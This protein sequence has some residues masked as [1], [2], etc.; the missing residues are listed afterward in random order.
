MTCAFGCSEIDNY[1]IP[2][3][4]IYGTVIDDISGEPIQTEQ[5]NGYRMKL[6]KPDYEDAIP[7]Y[8]WGMEDGSFQNTKIASDRYEIVP[9]DG[10]FFPPEPKLVDVKGFTELSFAVTPF[11]KIIDV[12]V[13]SEGNSIIT[14]YALS[15][16]KIGEKIAVQATLC[17]ENPH[18]NKT[19]WD[20]RVYSDLSGIAD[21]TILATQSTDTIK[22]LKSGKT[23]YIR[24]G[25]ATANALS[26]FNY[27]KTFQI[28]IQ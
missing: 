1:S 10:A 4:G 18:V 19:V 5:P 11:L 23:Y 22:G 17:S 20:K 2:D 14:S 21:E 16:N 8:F 24:V 28:T 26:R 13:K 15:R 12:N 9:V 27:S 7:L 3:A 6:I 25:A